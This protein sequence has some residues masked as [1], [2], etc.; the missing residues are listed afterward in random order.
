[1]YFTQTSQQNIEL[2]SLLIKSEL[3]DLLEKKSQL[4]MENGSVYQGEYDSRFGRHGFG[5][6][7]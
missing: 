7:T 2:K 5:R 4:K 3:S 1:M 6:L